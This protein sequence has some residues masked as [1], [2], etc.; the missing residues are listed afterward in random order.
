M[1]GPTILYTFF[2]AV[3]MA[4]SCDNLSIK[5]FAK[6]MLG[7]DDSSSSSP[8]FLAWLENENRVEWGNLMAAM[9]HISTPDWM[10]LATTAMTN[11]MTSLIAMRYADLRIVVPDPAKPYSV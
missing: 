2:V 8:R 6:F 11:L 3:D 9:V 7:D 10:A 1:H 5:D 4:F